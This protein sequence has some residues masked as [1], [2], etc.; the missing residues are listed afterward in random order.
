MRYLTDQYEHHAEQPHPKKEL[1][2][3]EDKV[4]D[5]KLQPAC[6]RCDGIA[7]AVMNDVRYDS[8]IYKMNINSY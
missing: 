5:P 8:K 6:Q 4:L 1:V 7:L 3:A 2:L